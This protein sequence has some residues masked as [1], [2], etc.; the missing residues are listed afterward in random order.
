MD[1]LIVFKEL[2]NI[3]KHY[4]NNL[5]CKTDDESEYFLNTKHL[6]KN[7]NPLYFGSVKINKQTV[8]YHLMPVYVEPELLEGISDKLMKR[9]QG[10]SCFNFKTIDDELFEELRELTEKGFRYYRSEGF[11]E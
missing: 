11:V 5:D 3:L 10:K 6:M 8:S 9:M 4:E 1:L 7:K 2:K